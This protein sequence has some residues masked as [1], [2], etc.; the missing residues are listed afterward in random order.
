MYHSVVNNLKN[1]LVA[2]YRQGEL[3]GFTHEGEITSAINLL[4]TLEPG[5]DLLFSGD[6]DRIIGKI[7]AM[8]A[9]MGDLD[10]PEILRK[11]VKSMA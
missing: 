7:R 10:N 5:R 11:H 8:A 3:D 1:Q 4:Y 2:M 6:T 9:D